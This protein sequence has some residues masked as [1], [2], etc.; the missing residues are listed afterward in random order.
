MIGNLEKISDQVDETSISNFEKKFEVV[1]PVEY[2]NFLLETNG[3]QPEQS[4]VSVKGLK[5]GTTDLKLFLALTLA[6]ETYSLEWSMESIR[7]WGSP[8]HFVPIAIDSGG[9]YFL[10]NTK[11][12]TISYK[13]DFKMSSDEPELID[14]SPSFTS[15]VDMIEPLSHV[16]SRSRIFH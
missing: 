2:R 3:G 1:I 9:N 15:F 6:Q 7:E 16:E 5:G 13:N 10:I 11:N 12:G 14:V 4:I 8:S